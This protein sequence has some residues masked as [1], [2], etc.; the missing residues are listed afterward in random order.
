MSLTPNQ[1]LYEYRIERVLGQGA[2]GIVYL[3]H[4]T[5]LD[6]PVAIKELTLTAQA[7]EVAFQRFLQEARAAGNLN[8]PHIVTV[9]TLKVAEPSVYLVMEYLA[10]G[11]LRALLER[12]GPLPVVDAVRIAADVCEGLAAAHARGIVH[13]DVKPENVLLTADGQAKIGDFGIAHVPLGAG[14]TSLTQAGFQ[15]GT[16][17][18]MSPEQIR[19]QVVDGR[20]DVYQ[21]GALLYEMLTGRHY[22]D[23]GALERQ[24]RDT[25]G[26][27]AA[28]FQARLYELLAEAVC[29]WEPVGVFQARAEVPEWVGKTVVAALAKPIEQRPQVEALAQTLRNGGPA[30]GATAL[31]SPSESEFPLQYQRVPSAEYLGQV[32][33]SVIEDH[34]AAQSVKGATA[35][36]QCE[37]CH[38]FISAQVPHHA[39]AYEACVCGNCGEKMYVV[40]YKIGG[41]LARRTGYAI[42]AL[43]D[44]PARFLEYMQPEEGFID[45]RD[46][47]RRI[48]EYTDPEWAHSETLWDQKF[49]EI[50]RAIAKERNAH[51]LSLSHTQQAKSV[52]ALRSKEAA[53]SM[54]VTPSSADIALAE[55][56]LNRGV[57]Y[58]QEGHVDDALRELQTALRI[59]PNLAEAHYNLGVTY[60][61]Q[62]RV[63]EAI[64]EFQAAL[65]IKPNL[66]EA[67]YSLG[68]TYGQQDRW[69]EA[70]HE[71]QTALRI[72]PNYAKA[73]YSLGIAYG[74]QGQVDEEI[75]EY[76]AV[77]HINPNHAEA[78]YNL[79]VIY[80][81][82]G[83]LEDAIH[84]YQ[85][86]L[87]IDPNYAEAHYNLGI[88]YGQ[89][90]RVDD[91]IREFQA[92]LRINL[93]LAEAHYNLGVTY[94][95]QDRWDEA[96][97]EFQAALRINPNDAEA[98]Y[99]LGVA[100][101][102][103][104][105]LEDEI[106]EYQAALRINPDYAN[107]HC[108]LGCVYVQQGRVDDAI[109]EFQAAL[110]INPDYAEAH[111]DLG[112]AYVQQGRLD[113]AIREFQA[114]LRTNPYYAKA[115]YDLGF[116]YEQQGHLDEAVSEFQAALRVNPNYV[117]AHFDLGVA[118]EQQGHLSEA[119]REFQAAIRINP[120]NA[121]AH[122]NLGVAYMQQDR[123]DEAIHEY[124]AALRINPNL[125]EAHLDLG[126]A[127]GQQ[128]RWDDAIRELHIAVRLGSQRASAFLAE[129]GLQ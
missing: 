92:A 53:H 110:Y 96:I 13:R 100:Y 106:R 5:F 37:K 84:E 45:P 108:N 62:G 22:V 46:E 76:Q 83:H 51:L 54:P 102:Q 128:R 55:E 117:E 16:L 71:F 3:A 59:D 36:F 120:N 47:L 95:Q 4:D 104:G 82:Q 40:L 19:G 43:T 80:T 109:R 14:G 115:H 74:E 61:Q 6:R 66:A 26:S 75:R 113:D 112:V 79:G 122:R 85:A 103:Q 48:V 98:H 87:R 116:V 111:D 94:G 64:Q 73:H 107:V 89:R 10:G 18:Y 8:H 93:N 49:V 69:D 129:M 27:N 97:H 31:R 86:A 9:H 44:I 32:Q 88:V 65:H 126:I 25:T 124:Q 127:Y 90:G 57:A 41:A 12:R 30:S 125:A 20:S 17:V 29:E 24:A 34:Y 78:H 56:H 38:E 123:L 35:L 42:I 15:P 99:N 1:L 7:D 21:V 119:A 68:A 114:A 23:M 28:L 101:G 2:F 121:E 11:S 72:N 60:G 118:Y 39:D 70:I 81:Q 58:W 50:Q 91:A 52:Q 77:L 105:C 67:H 63:D 33:C